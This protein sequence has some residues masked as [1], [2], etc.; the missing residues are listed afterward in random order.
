MSLINRTDKRPTTS[1]PVRGDE[2]VKSVREQVSEL[3]RLHI[4]QTI[5]EN[6]Q[7]EQDY[8]GRV[9]PDQWTAVGVEMHMTA[10]STISK[11]LMRHKEAITIAREKLK[12][13]HSTLHYQFLDL[14]GDTENLKQD[15]C[16]MHDQYQ[17]NDRQDQQ[18][19]QSRATHP[20]TQAEDIWRVSHPNKDRGKTP[21]AQRSTSVP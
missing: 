19:Q 20:A 6:K 2:Y 8:N 14:V 16:S 1:L 3:T 21:A 10:A 9:V 12:R 5:A 13:E 7:S 4:M 15:L 18:Q 17:C 11:K